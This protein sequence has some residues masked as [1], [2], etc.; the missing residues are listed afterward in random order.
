MP[1]T[2]PGGRTGRASGRARCRGCRR[3]SRATHPRRKREVG[4]AASVADG[5]VDERRIRGRHGDLAG[6]PVPRPRCRPTAWSPPA[7]G[8][9]SCRSPRRLR[10]WRG[11]CRRGAGRSSRSSRSSVPPRPNRSGRR[12]TGCLR[13]G[14]C[15]G[16]DH[17]RARVAAGRLRG[18]AC[19]PRSRTAARSP[20][21]PCAE[22]R[23][24]SGR[25]AA[26]RQG[27]AASPL[28]PVSRRPPGRRGRPRFRARSR[29]SARGAA[30]GW[31]DR[32]RRPGAGGSPTPVASPDR[33]RRP[34]WGASSRAASAWGGCAGR[35]GRP[36]TARTRPDR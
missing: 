9:R 13:A 33:C 18:R 29:R 22:T 31:G 24:R 30:A 1:R 25:A 23:R 35:S 21:T 32:R 11:S 27:A 2:R 36:A 26:R 3:G 15:S 7:G 28:G 8:L 20:P 10:P 14:P 17:W 4:R 16:S 12:R 5:P 19:A 34:S 6:A